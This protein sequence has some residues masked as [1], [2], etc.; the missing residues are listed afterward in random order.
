MS[1]C[2]EQLFLLKGFCDGEHYVVEDGR[3]ISTS[4]DD[5]DRCGVVAHHREMG[6]GRKLCEVDQN[7]NCHKFEYIY[8][9]I[10]E[11]W[12]PDSPFGNLTEV[13]SPPRKG[14]ICV[15]QQRGLG[16]SKR[17]VIHAG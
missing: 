9:T 16:K 10:L 15:G 8:V 6:E 13:K 1:G 17:S 7:S 5:V 4:P 3:P 2:Q 11:A 14:G 12:G